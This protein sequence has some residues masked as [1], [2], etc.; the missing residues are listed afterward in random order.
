MSISGVPGRVQGLWYHLINYT[1]KLEFSKKKNQ[2]K[3]LNFENNFKS[4]FQKVSFDTSGR[5][6]VK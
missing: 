3:Y 6:S 2:N 5:N 1:T 4:K